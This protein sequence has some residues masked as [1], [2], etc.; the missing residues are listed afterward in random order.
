MYTLLIS[1]AILAPPVAWLISF[2]HVGA[3]ATGILASFA[4]AAATHW[5]APA[6]VRALP[7]RA[8][9]RMEMDRATSPG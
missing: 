4:D 8:T 1:L 5:I 2:S 3:K 6:F 9:W 7:R